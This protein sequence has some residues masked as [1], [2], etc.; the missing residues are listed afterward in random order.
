MNTLKIAII[1][2]EYEFL[3]EWN[4]TEYPQVGDALSILHLCSKEQE[5]IFE[6][7]PLPG[8][9]DKEKER[10][11]NAAEYIDYCGFIVTSRLWGQNDTLTIFCKRDD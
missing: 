10:C 4:H 3:C 6:K 2:L 9:M 7:M 8:H 5:E 1:E 11:N